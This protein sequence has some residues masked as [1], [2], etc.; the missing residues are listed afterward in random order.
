MELD[1]MS[2]Q[3]AYLRNY[4]YSVAVTIKNKEIFKVWLQKPV[5]EFLTT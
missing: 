1:D 4:T 3:T 2:I 5:T